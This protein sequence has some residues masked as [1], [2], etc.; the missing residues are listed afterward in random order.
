MLQHLLEH[1]WKLE[2]DDKDMIVMYHQFQFE[3][4][5]EQKEVQSSMVCIGDNQLYTGMAKTVGLPVGI[6]AK[7]ILNGSIGLTGVHLPINEK[8]YTPILKEL[9]EYNIL[10]KEQDIENIAEL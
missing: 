8:I 7:N 2:D 1:K 3:L 10:F 4:N 9:E 6:A 5:G